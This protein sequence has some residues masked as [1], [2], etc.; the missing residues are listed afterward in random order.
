[1]PRA[2]ATW[3]DTE[4]ADWTAGSRVREGKLLAQLLQNLEHLAQSHRH[5]G[6]TADGAT[7]PVADPKAILFYAQPGLTGE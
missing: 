4:T 2:T 1:M 3:T 6:G 7:L 5:G